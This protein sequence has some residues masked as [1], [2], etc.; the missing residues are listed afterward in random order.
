[1]TMYVDWM[2]EICE[3]EPLDI[4]AHPTWIPRKFN[5][6][7]DTLWTEK[8]QKKFIDALKRTGTALEI[9]TGAKLPKLDFLKMAKEAG[10]KFS[11]GSNS[12]GKTV[13]EPTYGIEMAKALGLTAKDMFVPAP[14]DR[15]PMLI[16]K[17]RT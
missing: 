13:N 15:K 8:R 4:F 3:R 16:R 12:G 2:V 5:A 11:F 14:R 7:F 9:D 17:L 10:L 6:L 1:M